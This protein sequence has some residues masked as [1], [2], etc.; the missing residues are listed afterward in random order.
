MRKGGFSSC[1]MTSYT[2]FDRDENQRLLYNTR[3]VKAIYSM[4]LLYDIN[5]SYQLYDHFNTIFYRCY[6]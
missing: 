4:I 3:L 1:L 5:L 2:W 6:L